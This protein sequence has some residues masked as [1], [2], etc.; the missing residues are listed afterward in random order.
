MSGAGSAKVR[1][2]LNDKFGM[3]K[4]SAR[5][6][7]YILDYVVNPIRLAKTLHSHLHYM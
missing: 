7:F 1:G 3:K 4:R 6:P 2:L 5:T